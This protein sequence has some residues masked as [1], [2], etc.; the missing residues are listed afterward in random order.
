MSKTPKPLSAGEELFALHCK[1]LG[2]TP[3]REF[4]FADGRKYAFDFAWPDKMLAVE[5]DG[6][7]AFGKSRH[8]QGKGY[9]N[10]CRK[11]NLAAMLGWKVMRYTSEMVKTAEAIDAVSE[12]LSQ[13]GKP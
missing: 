10:D 13:K 4:R 6:G 7:T 2:L 1:A 8:S 5:I 11:L 9:E 3:V 12:F